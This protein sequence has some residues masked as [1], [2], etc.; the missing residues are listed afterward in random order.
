[1]RLSG[2]YCAGRTPLKRDEDEDMEEKHEQDG[3]FIPA[4]TFHGSK[5]GYA[6]KTCVRG[7]GYYLDS[8][9]EKAEVKA[10]REDG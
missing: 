7:V 10:E 3:W 2:L 5:D 1:M 9:V 4:K 6:F 8:K